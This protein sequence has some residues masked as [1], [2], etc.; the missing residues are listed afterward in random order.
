MTPTARNAAKRSL[1]SAVTER[2]PLKLAAIF[3]AIV[4]WLVVSAEEPTQEIVNVRFTPALD[5]GVVSTGGVP[6]VRALVLGSGRELLKLYNAQPVI[7]RRVRTGAGD[8]VRVE[9]GPADVDLPAGV[10][11]VVRDVRPRVVTL[12]VQRVAPI[13]AGDTATDIQHPVP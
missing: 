4:L 7:V 1:H 12:R 10:N 2:L 6:S 8:S 13:P 3:F 11:A 5:S 9:L